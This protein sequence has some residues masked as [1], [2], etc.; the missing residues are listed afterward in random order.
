MD[1]ESDAARRAHNPLLSGIVAL[2]VLER[3]VDGGAPPLT[4]DGPGFVLKD[5]ALELLPGVEGA[6]LVEHIVFDAR[7]GMELE[8]LPV[9]RWTGRP[10]TGDVTVDETYD[11]MEAVSR[12]VREVLG[13]DTVTYMGRP[14]A[15][16]VHYG[17]GFN[18]AFWNGALMVLGDGGAVFGRFSKC[19]EVI[20]AELWRGLPEISDLS[21]RGENGAL[22][23]SLCDV[24]GSLIKQ[25]ALGQTAEEA[26]WVLGAGLLA[27]GAG[28]AGLRSLKAPGTAYDNETLGKDPQPAHMDGYVRTSRDNGGIHINNGI[29]SHAFYRLASALGGPAW[30]RAGLIWWDALTDGEVGEETLFADFARLTLKAARERYGEDGEEYRAARTAWRDVGV[31]S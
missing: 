10:A 26:D 18:N 16:V 21:Y 15:A 8:G 9:A 28:G 19:V 27:P 12:F 22:G 20:G 25:Y 4:Y 14:I 11:G 31:T 29:P 23:T 17:E 24:F 3:M 2:P 1:L 13:R 7:G 30:E 5:G 6:G